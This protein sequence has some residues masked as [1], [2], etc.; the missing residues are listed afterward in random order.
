MRDAN[1]L[2]CRQTIEN[3]RNTG[4]KDLYDALDIETESQK[5]SLDY[6]LLL[7]AKAA[8]GGNSLSA[9]IDFD[10]VNAFA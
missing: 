6:L 5:A 9:F 1:A 7:S 3:A 8:D 2:L 4:L 10:S